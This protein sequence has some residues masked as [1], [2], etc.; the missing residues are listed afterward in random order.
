MAVP[1]RKKS[2]AKTHSRRATHDVVTAANPGWC[3]HCGAPK[4]P[5]HACRECGY[6]KGRQ[7]LRVVQ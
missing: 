2:H 7:V 5:H 6:Y 3:S 1:K 4:L